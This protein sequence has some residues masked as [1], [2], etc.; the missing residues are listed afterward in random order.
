MKTLKV[1]L[2]YLKYLFWLGPM[3]VLAGLTAGVVS[4]SWGVLPL[5]LI[6]TGIVILA[7]WLLFLSRFEESPNRPGFWR[8][9][10]TQAG[11]NAVVA[12]LAVLA[13]LGLINFLGV[14]YAGRVD[15]TENQVFTLAPETQQLVKNLKQP[16]KVWVFDPQQSDQDREL[17]ESYRRLGQNFS[18][19]FVNPN[20]QPSLTQQF[21]VKKVGDVYA[22]VPATKRRQFVQT[23]SAD[24]RLNET[25][26]TNAIA[27]A[28]STQQAS[29]YVLQGHGERPIEPSQEAISQ[30]AKVLQ[31][32]GYAV[33]S[34]N[35][36][37]TASLPKDAKVIVM[38][39]PQKPLLKGEVTALE[40]YLKQGGNLLLMVD[41]NANPGLD[42][43]LSSWGVS[44]DPRVVI[45]ASKRIAELGPADV[46]VTQYSDHPITKDFGNNLSFFTAARAVDVKPVPGVQSTPLLVTSDR[47]WAESDIKSQP[48]K[49]DPQ[50]DR[51]GPL[52]LGFALSRPAEST[53]S[54]KPSSVPAAKPEADN[55]KKESRLVVIGNSSF[56]A[57]GYFNQVTNGDVFLNSVRWLSQQEQP[58][59]SLRPKE[60]K[61]RRIT[62]SGQQASLVGWLSLVILPLVGFGTAAAVWWRRR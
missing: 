13:I 11:A 57:D 10:S 24:D 45:D 51:K 55:P 15:L 61:N 44:F 60:A 17:L 29:V 36:T 23:V 9:R 47:T 52:V 22:E 43:L 6:I 54:S 19:E 40:N 28:T 50:V 26:L 53:P 30:A 16:V 3:L 2:K 46:T 7:L 25:K 59:L 31:D 35:L 41:P 27:Q 5:G 49:F 14:R 37:E 48:V 62:L 58:T 32:K 20:A 38:A 34:L 33:K 21:E 42:D 1:N 12:T 56:A 8:R 18:Y 4:S 39:G